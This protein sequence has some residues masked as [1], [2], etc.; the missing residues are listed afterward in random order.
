M[1]KSEIYYNAEEIAK[2]MGVSIGK[3]Y[4]VIRALNEELEKRGYL[5]VR[6]KVSKSFFNEKCYKR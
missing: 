1:S 6:G 5:V 2:I 4:K 3:A